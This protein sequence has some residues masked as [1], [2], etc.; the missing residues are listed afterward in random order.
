MSLGAMIT[1]RDVDEAQ[2]LKDMEG[3]VK[4]KDSLT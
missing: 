1:K 3:Y 2:L 4:M